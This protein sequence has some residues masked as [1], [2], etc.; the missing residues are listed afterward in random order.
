MAV[1]KFF[2]VHFKNSDQNNI[3]ASTVFK[4]K[5]EK[6]IK[7]YLTPKKRAFMSFETKTLKNISSYFIF[8]L[9]LKTEDSQM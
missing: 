2:L 3:C 5:A 9:A 6:S 7:N 4:A 1:S 8:V